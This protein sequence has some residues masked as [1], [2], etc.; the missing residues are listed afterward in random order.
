MDEDKVQVT[1]DRDRLKKK[2]R[3]FSMTDEDYEI[4]QWI[5]DFLGTDNKSDVVRTAIRAMAMQLA[6]LGL[7]GREPPPEGVPERPKRGRPRGS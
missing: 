4:L 5:A 3:G 2:H 6:Q 1:Y 7:P